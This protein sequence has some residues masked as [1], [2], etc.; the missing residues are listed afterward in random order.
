MNN[1]KGFPGVF[2]MFFVIFQLELINVLMLF[3]ELLL[4]IV[5]DIGQRDVT[6]VVEIDNGGLHFVRR[7]ELEQ[8][9]VIE[10]A[11]D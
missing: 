10:D 7:V 3:V 9:E 8:E 6:R 4:C 11:H 2:H 5:H 1:L